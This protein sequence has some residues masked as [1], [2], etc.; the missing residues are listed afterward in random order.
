M[1]RVWAVL[2]FEQVKRIP[3]SW[4]HQ[5]QTYQGRA[6][7]DLVSFETLFLTFLRIAAARK[8]SFLFT[9]LLFFLQLLGPKQNNKGHVWE[10][11][12]LGPVVAAGVVITAGA[13]VSEVPEM[14]SS[15]WPYRAALFH[16]ARRHYCPGEKDSHVCARA[17]VFVRVYGL[18]S[19]QSIWYSDKTKGLRHDWKKAE[20]V[21]AG[22]LW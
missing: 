9:I 21:F 19:M 8:L 7:T 13:L 17:C 6:D 14:R 18:V 22:S 15:R 5:Q 16:Q 10:D 2:L 1:S 3:L 4:W 20:D 11:T 12:R